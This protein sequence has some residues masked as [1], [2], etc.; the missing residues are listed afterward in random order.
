MSELSDAGALQLNAAAKARDVEAQSSRE[1]PDCSFPGINAGAPPRCRAFRM[2]PHVSEE[3]REVR[4][5]HAR[6][7]GSPQDPEGA[8][9]F[10]SGEQALQGLRWK[11]VK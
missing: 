4:R 3:A 5:E 10:Q 1:A 8:P 7:A 9:D 11:L 6:F 2:E